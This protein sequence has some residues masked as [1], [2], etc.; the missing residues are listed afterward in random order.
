MASM[1]AWALCSSPDTLSAAGGTVALAISAVLATSSTGQGVML[2]LQK[3]VMQPVHCMRLYTTSEA[4]KPGGRAP[5]LVLLCATRLYQGRCTHLWQAAQGRSPPAEAGSQGCSCDASPLASWAALAQGP[6]QTCL[7][8][9][10]LAAHHLP[11]A[12]SPPQEGLLPHRR[13]DQ[14]GVRSAGQPWHSQHHNVS[15]SLCRHCNPP[16]GGL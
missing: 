1:V 8:T 15:W 10:F 11:W 4:D 16:S 3:I 7:R 6:L 14:S 13:G 12:A 5:T 2:L 9:I